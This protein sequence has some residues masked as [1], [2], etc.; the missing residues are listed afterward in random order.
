MPKPMLPSICLIK[1][2]ASV[3][4]QPTTVSHLFGATLT[5]VFLQFQK[6]IVTSL[7]FRQTVT[8]LCN[9]LMV[10]ISENKVM[11][12]FHY[13]SIPQTADRKIIIKTNKMFFKKIIEIV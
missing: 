8:L 9:S 12:R 1:T 4:S 10:M 7:K 13:F 2:K 11:Q 3:S 6:V 5:K